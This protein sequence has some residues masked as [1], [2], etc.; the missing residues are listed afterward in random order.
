MK[1]RLLDSLIG[2]GQ[3]DPKG[4]KRHGTPSSAVLAY[5]RFPVWRPQ[6]L[7][8]FPRCGDG[9]PGNSF[10]SSVVLAYCMDLSV[11]NCTV[12][13]S[14]AGEF[15]TAESAKFWYFRT[16]HGCYLCPES[17]MHLLICR[18]TSFGELAISSQ[19]TPLSRTPKGAI[20]RHPQPSASHASWQSNLRTL[21]YLI[22]VWQQQRKPP[23]KRARCITSPPSYTSFLSFSPAT[24]DQSLLQVRC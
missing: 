8:S 13:R 9:L 23:L 1:I 10:L 14:L 16:S 24:L 11:F 19:W 5:P 3:I 17:C 12:L 6:S 21:N 22:P 18:V 4:K 20:H 2:R 15:P 7:S